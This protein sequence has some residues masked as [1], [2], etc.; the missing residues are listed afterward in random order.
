MK[1]KNDPYG[2][3]CKINPKIF[4]Q[5]RGSQKGGWGGGSAIWEKFPKNTVF[6]WKTPLRVTAT[7]PL[8]TPRTFGK[9][10]KRNLQK[11]A[12]KLVKK[13]MEKWQKK[14]GG[15]VKKSA[16][17]SV[18]KKGK[19]VGKNF[20]KF[21]IFIIIKNGEQNRQEIAT[22]MVGKL[23]KKSIS[24]HGFMHVCSEVCM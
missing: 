10:R 15:N 22:T 8:V 9:I 23:A 21:F 7:F 19:N 13:V 11:T 12:Q 6:F 5:L 4:F 18:E 20:E 2:L 3:K 17:Q 1:T 16:K 24:Q 14:I